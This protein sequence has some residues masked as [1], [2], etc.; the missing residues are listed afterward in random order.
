MFWLDSDDDWA[1][2][3]RRDERRREF[4][5]AAKVLASSWLPNNA[6]KGASCQ[7]TEIPWTGRTGDDDVMMT[8]LTQLNS[9]RGQCKRVVVVG[10]DIIVA[11]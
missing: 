7:T 2:G 11:D 5:G 10:F 9:V 3:C 1:N 8:E 4:L 6:G